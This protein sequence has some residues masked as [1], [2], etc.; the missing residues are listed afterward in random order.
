[1]KT[2][3]PSIKKELKE[4]SEKIRELKLLRGPANNGFIP[5][6]GTLQL[7]YRYKHV[8]YCMFHGTKYEDIE[9]PKEENAL[10]MAKVEALIKGYEDE[11][12]HPS[13]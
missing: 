6:L 1:M 3:L 12:L 13:L 11:T 9:C 4:L 8:S 2:K 5:E 10:D 7:K